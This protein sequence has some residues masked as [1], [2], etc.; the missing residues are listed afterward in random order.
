MFFI[1]LFF[2][3]STLTCADPITIYNQTTRDLYV[4]LYSSPIKIP[5]MP[6]QSASRISDPIAIR[7]KS[8]RIIERPSWQAARNQEMVFVDAYVSDQLQ[9][10]L[11]LDQLLMFHAK[12]VG[13]LQGSTFYIVDSE[14]D[15]YAYNT[16]QWYI[17]Q[18]ISE[19]AQ[20]ALS[21]IPAIK[22]NFYK[23]AVAQI[24]FGNELCAQEKTYRAQ[25]AIYVKQGI[26]RLTCRPV[27]EDRIPQVALIC[28]GGG[29]RAMLYTLGVLCAAEDRG[30]LDCL[31][32]IVG[33][34]GS[35]WAVGSWF[36]SGKQVRAYHDWLI[37]H[38]CFSVQDFD[39]EDLSLTSEILL[40]KYFSGQP[41]GFV[42]CYGSFIA[43]DLFD[44]FATN[45]DRV[46]MSGQ[47]L[48]VNDG[49]LPLPI[50]TAISAESDVDENYWYEF[51]P[52]EVGASWL[53]MYV[54]T[55]AFGRKF[56]NGYSV[57]NDPEQSLST[58][59]AT[60]GLAVGVTIARLIKEYNIEQKI[61]SRLLKKMVA[62]IVQTIGTDR[63]ISAYFRNFT[64]GITQSPYG[65]LTNLKFVDAGINCNLPYPP[66]SGQRPDRL[67]DIII[68]ADASLDVGDEL[69]IVEEYAHTHGLKFPKITYDTISKQAVSIFKDDTD[70]TVPIVI[71]IP[72][73]VDE[74]LLSTYRND[75]LYEYLHGFDI[76][77][78]V[79]KESCN[80]FNFFYSKIE[81]RRMTALGEFN[82][83][84]AQDALVCALNAVMSR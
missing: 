72:R 30:I 4:A 57:S 71:Y 32:Y 45:K 78:C 13:M 40:T 43:N 77:E 1:A 61:S 10:A 50:Y 19:S 23:D 9:Q 54:P 70:A 25:R 82:M 68:I 46:Y 47:Q 62:A 75:P 73:I 41:I 49:S 69:K 80:T 60:F 37:D 83:K 84:M 3:I 16:A 66:V 18:G 51:T 59:F 74:S 24:R 11:S 26:E 17:A 2:C 14:G 81:S 6:Q 7:A 55:W 27:H 56:K 42:D 34:S 53:G 52:Y 8:S 39:Q 15:F 5:F 31:T 20:A 12:D 65:T 58:L 38:L 64:R 76:E 21:L 22:N 48:R 28:S 36:S 67:M 44:L 79:A 63:P 33:L 29:Y 35:T